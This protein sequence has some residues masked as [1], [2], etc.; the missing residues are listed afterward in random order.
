MQEHIPRWRHP[1]QWTVDRTL[2]GRTTNVA[3]GLSGMERTALKHAIL[4]QVIPVS[5]VQAAL[6]PGWFKTE[7]REDYFFFL[8]LSKQDFRDNHGDR[9]WGVFPHKTGKSLIVV[10]TVDDVKM[11]FWPLPNKVDNHC[12]WKDNMDRNYYT[13][14]GIADRLDQQVGA[15]KI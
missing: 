15:G 13:F 6:V 4:E 5:F 11:K 10:R 8:F 2:L 7:F 9:R 1:P 12:W 14:T 3:K